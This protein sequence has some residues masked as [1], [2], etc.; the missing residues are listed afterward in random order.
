M[1]N[2]FKAVESCQIKGLDEIYNHYFPNKTD[3]IFVEVGAYNGII[4]SNTYH[5]AKLGWTGYMFEP[6]PRLVKECMENYKNLNCNIY[7]IGVSNKKGEMT[8]YDGDALS[9][10]SA[11]QVKEYKKISWAKGQKYTP[12]KI[13]VDILDSLLNV[14][15]IDILVIDTEGTELDVLEGFDIKK[16]KPEMCIIEAHESHQDIV[17]RKNAEG[18]NKYFEKVKYIKIYSDEINN[19]YISP[20]LHK[21]YGLCE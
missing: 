11:E 14:E 20:K 5:L 19:I 4:F 10:T 13:K 16:F 3:G 12:I 15:T 1:E 7:N 18:I 8:L 17:L 2:I 6:H 21:K 9:T